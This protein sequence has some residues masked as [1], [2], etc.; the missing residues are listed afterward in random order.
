MTKSIKIFVA[1]VF[2]SFRCFGQELPTSSLYQTLKKSDSLLFEETF[3]KCNFTPLDKIIHP[4][5]IFLHDQ[6][7]R[8]NKAEFLSA[9]KQNICGNLKQKPIRKLTPGTLTVYPLHRDGVLYGAVQMGDHEF[10]IAE[11]GKPLQATSTAK[12]IHT[13]I[14][15]DGE[16]K[17]YF[18][19]S[20]HHVP[21]K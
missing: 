16:W 10:Y 14:L 18:V 21:S 8:Q 20:Y 9:V 12:F 1:V 3:N 17:L 19:Q 6:S 7:G 2:V 11:T 15:T 4:D 5:L 13:W